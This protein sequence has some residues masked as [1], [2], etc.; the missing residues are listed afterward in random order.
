MSVG[1]NEQTIKDYKT[2]NA[3]VQGSKLTKADSIKDLATAQKVDSI[4][5]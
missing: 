2:I 3:K 1:A 4:P 5:L